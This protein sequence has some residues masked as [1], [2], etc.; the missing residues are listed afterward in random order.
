MAW[1][2][3]E[4]PHG[5]EWQ[6]VRL[7]VLDVTAGTGPSA[8]VPRLLAKAVTSPHRISPRALEWIRPPSSTTFPVPLHR[9]RSHSTSC[10]PV[11]PR[12]HHNQRMTAPDR[13]HVA[14]ATKGQYNSVSKFRGYMLWGTNGVGWGEALPPSGCQHALQ[15][16]Q[17]LGDLVHAVFRVQARVGFVEQGLHAGLA[18]AAE[19]APEAVT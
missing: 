3:P 14:K 19:E 11:A 16:R 5:K 13:T 9:Q 2:G 17:S 10:P 15:Q 7:H 6:A 1:P 8:C 4:G 18:D 12:A